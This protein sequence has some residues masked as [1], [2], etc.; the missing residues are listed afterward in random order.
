MDQDEI[1]Q[2]CSSSK[3][4]RLTDSYFDNFVVVVVIHCSPPKTDKQVLVSGAVA[5]VSS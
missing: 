3:M 4:H 2:D 1:W 5:K